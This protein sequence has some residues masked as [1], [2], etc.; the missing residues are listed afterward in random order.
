MDQNRGQSNL[1]TTMKRTTLNKAFRMAFDLMDRLTISRFPFAAI[2]TS[3]ALMVCLIPSLP[4]EE[5][6]D[7][8]KEDKSQENR[9][10]A[11]YGPNTKVYCD[12][13]WMRVH[14][15]DCPALILKEKKKTMTLEEADKAG[16]RIGESGQSG[17]DHCCLQGYRRKY[18]KT[19]IPEDSSG[20]VHV[21]KSGV[22]K[23]HLVGCHRFTPM[24][25][26]RRMTLKEAK[27]AKC[28]ICPHCIER[29]PSL[30]TISD[31]ELK[32]LPSSKGFVPPEGWVPEPYSLD[33]LPPK[34]ELDILIQETL[35]KHN[36]IQE[37]KYEDPVATAEHFMCMRFFFPVTNWLAF[38]KA[39]RSTGDKRLLDKL[40]ESARHYNKLSTE[41]P[42]VAQLKASDPEGMPFMYS[43]AV[44]AR[45][46]LQLAR[47]YPSEVSTKDVEEAEAFLKTMVSVLKPTCEG[48]DALD[49]DMG[50]P[51]TLAD[52]FR[53]R[54]FNRA[55]N[56]IGTLSMMTAALE[57]LQTLRSTKEYQPSINRYRKIMK[58]YIKHW[59]SIGCLYTEMDGKEYF[60]YPY[61]AG[62]KGKMV[63]GF[64]LYKGPEDQ[65]HYTHTLQGLMCIYEST[66]E[67]GIDDDFMT[68]VANAVYH[69]SKTKNGSIQCPSADKKRPAS[70]KRYGGARERFYMLEAFT[71]G[72]IDGQCCTLNA[73][74]KNAVN[75]D[76]DHRLATLHAQY[77]K[78]LRKDRTLIHLGEKEQKHL[79]KGRG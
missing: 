75:S 17:R 20:I 29:G 52:D 66:P 73:A 3:I 40:L 59:R 7:K 1:R 76:Y 47:K 32:K 60:Y 45:I 21:L 74:R 15:E 42:S 22:L 65:G 30:T 18:P 31:E 4:A 28:L 43:M 51:R 14:A 63:D 56:G 64:K 8:V 13:L 57:D 49:P 5:D 34:E 71:E 78:A 39:Y 11:E 23:W 25:D 46:T 48:D 50:I 67:V 19:K 9:G 12:A 37:C 44:C 72:I 10:P 38:Y 2:F 36:G 69:N 77:M 68:A 54:A 16:W 70:R 79:S 35:A 24:S 55:M 61:A 33:K 6:G 62:D 41:Y 53:N 58:E 26:H 27:E